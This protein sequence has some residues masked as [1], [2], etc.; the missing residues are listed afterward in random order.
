MTHALILKEKPHIC[1]HESVRQYGRRPRSGKSWRRLMVLQPATLTCSM[2]SAGQEPKIAG[3]GTQ[4]LLSWHQGMAKVKCASFWHCSLLKH[5]WPFPE[6]A[7][8]P[9][10]LFP[11]P[12]TKF[13]FHLHPWR[14]FSVFI[15]YPHIYSENNTTCST[16]VCQENTAHKIISAGRSL[17]V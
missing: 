11:T 6:G 4:C 2:H 16:E 14:L 3:F 9:K 7:A 13:M 17:E 10:I 15:V 5:A 8:R 1:V 12:V